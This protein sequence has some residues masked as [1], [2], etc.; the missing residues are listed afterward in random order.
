MCLSGCGH[1][2]LLTPGLERSSPSSTRPFNDGGLPA[3]GSDAARGQLW[4]LAAGQAPGPHVHMASI[5][6]W[7]AMQ[8]H[9]WW[10]NDFR[11]SSA[12]KQLTCFLSFWR[13]RGRE[14]QRDWINVCVMCL[15]VC[16]FAW[17]CVSELVEAAALA[18][19]NNW[20][21]CPLLY[22][23]PTSSACVRVCVWHSNT[24]L[25]IGDGIT[26]SP[27]QQSDVPAGP[28]W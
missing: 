18:T 2:R 13:M 12:P 11:G 27:R 22:F 9:A 15:H 6:K 17:V 25:C 8:W 3:G 28:G 24:S 10:R 7:A 4:S 23:E 20:N 19:L 5:K 21:S 14:L 26:W 1:Y 16:V